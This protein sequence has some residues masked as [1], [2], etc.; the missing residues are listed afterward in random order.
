M[1]A[2]GRESIKKL[3]AK[4]LPSFKRAG[5][6]F[7]LPPV[8]DV[9]RGLVVE[10]SSDPNNFYFWVMVQPLIIPSDTVVLSYG[11]RMRRTVGTERWPINA[12]HILDEMVDVVSKT[13][14]PFLEQFTTT[15]SVASRIS[16][17]KSPID[18]NRCEA[19]A[20][21]LARAGLYDDALHEWR[22]IDGIVDDKVKWQ[23]EVRDRVKHLES[24]FRR[25]PALVQEQL[26]Q[27]AQKTKNAL[28][29]SDL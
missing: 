12:P 17:V 28:R 25:D 2:K 18:P 9:L 8:G 5:N 22:K 24:L 1:T 11:F 23:V 13:A 29:L 21:C 19:V 26:D 6:L 4:R 10:G 16:E 3:L 15:V 7:T 20:A 14:L 27:W